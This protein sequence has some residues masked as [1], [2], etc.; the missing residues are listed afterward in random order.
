MLRL[1]SGIAAMMDY[2]GFWLGFV[3]LFG[4]LPGV[5]GG[6]GGLVWAWRAGRRGRRLILPALIGAVGAGLLVFAGAV[7]FFGA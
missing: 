2:Q 6:A 5:L 4:L 1:F 3:L 7:L